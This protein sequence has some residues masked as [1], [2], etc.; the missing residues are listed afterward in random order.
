MATVI[1]VRFKRAG[2]VYYFDPGEV[3]PRPD[4]DVVVETSRG[5]EM[6]RVVTGAREVD[7]DQIVAPLKKVVRIA[8][9]ED[10]ERDRTKRPEMA[11]IAVEKSQLAIFTSDNPRSE[12]PNAI[13]D[14]MV[15]G[16]GGKNNYLCIADRA[17]A[18]RTAVMTATAGDV[19]LVAGKGHEDYQIIGTT[20]HPFSDQAHLEEFLSQKENNNK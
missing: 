14:E 11:E 16:V 2:K 18:I 9:A 4:T 19:I 17:Q 1:G 5:I 7:D 20:K 6:G 12:E 8:T 13:I 3:W 10:I 15:A